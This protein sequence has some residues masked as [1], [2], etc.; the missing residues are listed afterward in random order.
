MVIVL[1]ERRDLPAPAP[2]PRADQARRSPDRLGA[3]AARGG[4][5]PSA[6]SAGP[7]ATFLARRSFFYAFALS[8][9]F[10]AILT[11]TSRDPIHSALWFASV[12]LFDLGAV[13]ARRGAVP[14]G[15]DGHR[16]RRGDHRDVPV[17]DHARPEEGRATYDRM[18]RAPFLATLDELSCMLGLVYFALLGIRAQ[19]PLTVQYRP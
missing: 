15:R 11:V 7:L 3:L 6:C 14:R 13:P 2:H 4:P 1:G 19:R 12:V 17:R 16:L 10:S 9:V 8:A 18:A 5:L